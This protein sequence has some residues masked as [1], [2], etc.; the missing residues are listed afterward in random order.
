MSQYQK[1]VIRYIYATA[2]AAESEPPLSM[3]LQ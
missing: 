2:N 3:Q 1:I